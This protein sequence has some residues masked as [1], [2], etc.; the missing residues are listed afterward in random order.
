MRPDCIAQGTLL[1]D[2]WGD[3]NGREIQ[4]GAD[5]CICRADS[6]CCAIEARHFKATVF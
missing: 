5:T 2:L 6:F 1:N 3:L 4:K